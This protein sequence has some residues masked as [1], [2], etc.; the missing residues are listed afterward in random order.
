M[1]V[2]LQHLLGPTI[3]SEMTALAQ[4]TGAV[5]LGQGFPDSDGPPAML[6]AASEAIAS[7]QNQYP[8]AIGVPELRHQIALRRSA[9]HGVGYDPD[10][11][12]VVTAGATEAVAAALIGLCDP[13]DEVVVFDPLYDS[14][15]A[16]IAMAGAR[17]RPVLLRYD[18][19]RFTFHPG[20]L[21]RAIGPRAKVLLLNSPHNP[22][23][24]V[25]DRAELTEI[26]HV[27]QAHG[28][29]AVT[30]EVYEYLTYD[31]APHLPLAALP[32]MRERTLTISSAGKTFSV[33]G[34]KV[35][36][37]CGPA[38]LAG[39]V[40]A[41][42]QYLTFGTGTPLQHAVA[43]GLRDEM[44]WVAKLRGSLQS[45]R[46]LLTRSLRAAGISTYTSE[47][48][49]FLQ[50]DARSLGYQ[51]GAALCRVLA[52]EAG[53]VAVPSMA[54]Y[55]HK[56]AG[57][58]LVRLAFCKNEDVLT[59]A[60]AALGAFARARQPGRPQ[61]SPFSGWEPALDEPALD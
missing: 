37:A 8:P 45:R 10:T 32:G 3:F 43:C 20:D 29:I 50:F 39:V 27:C 55:E 22:S 60:A 51:D 19:A 6:A 46:D 53:V 26:A 11:E 14:Y 44:A 49:Y 1:A 38:G 17:V 42:K 5:N 54:L 7:G 59:A 48:T 4:A 12:V 21:R 41:V 34:W 61:A 18:G 33:T 35:G 30:D 36:W 47:G 13:G 31:G 9:D 52:T 57:R 16:V 56:D 15:A 25:F 58:P 2:R 28:L 40:R 23:G 24:K